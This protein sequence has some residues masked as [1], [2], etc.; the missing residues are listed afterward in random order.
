MS[1]II[2]NCRTKLV[3]TINAILPTS[4]AVDFA[5]GYLFLSGLG[6]IEES[7]DHPQRLRFL[8]GNATDRQTL[9]HFAEAFHRVD[10]AQQ[11]NQ[12]ARYRNASE[13]RELGD[14]AVE[15]MRDALALMDQGDE[16][17]SVLQ[18]VVRLIETGRLS[19]RVY[20]RGRLH[21]KAYLFHYPEDGRYEK[22]MGI[23][24]SS[25]LSLAGLTHNTELNVAVHGNENHEQLSVWFEERWAESLD[26]TQAL[27][28]E[29]RL[30]WLLAEATPYDIY[31]KSLHALVAD[32]LEGPVDDG[33]LWD[34]ALTQS[35]A[36]FQKEAVKRGVQIIRDQGG[37]FISDVVGLGKSFIGAAILQH[38]RRTEGCKA[39]II[40]PKALQES[41]EEFSHQFDLGARVIPMSRL[42][43]RRNEL[44]H[45]KY[46]E[47]DFLLVDESHHFRHAS[48]QRYDALQT[49]LM[50]R[51]RKLCLLTATPRNKSAWD[52][53]HQIK[54]FHPGDQTFLPVDPPNLKRYFK[55]VEEGSRSLQS[56]L[57]PLLVRRTRRHI[58]RWYGCAEDSGRPLRELDESDAA[59]YLNGAKRAWVQVGAIRNYFPQR[60]LET[61]G[62][63]IDATYAGIYDSLRFRLGGNLK[64]GEEATGERLSYA[65]FGLWHYVL[66]IMQKAAPYQ[67]LQR[68][69]AN[70]RGL[71]RVMLFKRLESSVYAF[72]KTLERMIVVHENFLRCLDKG[73]IPAGDDAQRLLKGS[74]ALDEEELLDL[75]AQISSKYKIEDFDASRLY[76]DVS[77]DLELLRNMCSDLAGIT[78]EKDSKLQVLKEKLRDGIPRAS[79]KVLLFTQFAD[80]AQYIYEAINPGGADPAIAVIYGTDQSKIRVAARF[81]PKANAFVHRPAGDPDIRILI[82]T[83]VM[84]EGLNLQDGDV[85]VNYDL[86]WNPVRLIQRFGRIDR[87]GTENE[88]V[89]GFNFLPERALDEN[90]GLTDRLKARIQEIHDSIGEDAAILDKEE[91]INEESMFAIYQGEGHQM[92]LQEEEEDGVPDLTEAEA[93]FRRMQE[94]YPEEYERIRNLRGGIR[95][96][97]ALFSGRG[98]Y[99]FCQAGQFQQLYLVDGKG[100]IVSRD[101]T[102]ALLRIRCPREE[103]RALLPL[104]HNARIMDVK[105]L[106]VEEMNQ[107][108]AEQKSLYT[109][110]CLGH[111]PGHDF[112]FP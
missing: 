31:M 18:K 8:I 39:L 1:D 69:G 104:D 107:R 42:Q 23:V 56:L 34:D 57:K 33:T 36:D 13:A 55:L 93:F 17:E 3:D 81:A 10:E 54:L 38:F 97:R 19:I 99:V 43:E 94:E 98:S 96:S 76:A 111:I 47:Y 5:V 60:R 73:I 35:L 2:D 112:P 7:L 106:F 30:S 108:L 88:E 49:Y 53:Y 84:S 86:H 51:Q 12:A 67:D 83:D 4:E 16:D 14:G 95:S 25:N 91:R 9:E 44:S 41:W 102:E 27:L 63:N 32:R 74:D 37:V 50:R 64:E 62:Y 79:G 58:L 89:W 75:M 26:L 29:I 45:A 71:M 109:E 48:S 90:L 59:D 92:T 77:A 24:G 65:R 68:V 61:L 15:E 78:P 22:G 100:K 20:T 105:A 101:M 87:I 80:T 103:P 72:L 21:A 46:E 110:Q 52:I 85:I 40:C 66:P 6:A 11:H 28:E 70:L 82:A